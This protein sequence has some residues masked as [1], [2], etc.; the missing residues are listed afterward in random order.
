MS[1]SFKKI[2]TF[3]SIL[4]EF[5]T[6]SEGFR[7]N[8]Y[9]DSEGIPTIGYGYALLVKAGDEWNIKETLA[10]DLQFIFGSGFSLSVEDIDTLTLAVDALQDGNKATATNIIESHIFSFNIS[11]LSAQILF[12]FEVDRKEIAILD[13]FKGFRSEEHTSELQSH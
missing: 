8:V 10:G 3:D 4:R 1:I 9:A 13:R 7:S 12:D 11:E 2:A 5:I 6:G